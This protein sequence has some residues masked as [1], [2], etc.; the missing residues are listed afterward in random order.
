MDIGNIH[1][2]N[3]VKIA[4]VVPEISSRTY[5]QTHT[6]IHTHQNTLQPLLQQ[7]KDWYKNYSQ[8]RFRFNSIVAWRL[9]ITNFP[10]N[11][12]KSIKV[13]YNRPQDNTMQSYS[14]LQ[15]N[16]GFCVAARLVMLINSI[17]RTYHNRTILAATLRGS[18]PG[19]AI[20]IAVRQL[21]QTWKLRHYDIIDVVITQKL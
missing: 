4:C 16:Q 6:D 9:K 17:K 10:A 18:R 3:L 20:R 11:G 21:S 7:N 2:K 8:F 1:K 12:A 19:G 5:R 15:C 14:R 13:K